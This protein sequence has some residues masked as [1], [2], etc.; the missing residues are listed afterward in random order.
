MGY[1]LLKGLIGLRVKKFQKLSM[2]VTN[3][4]LPEI[5]SLLLHQLR[6]PDFIPSGNV[7]ILHLGVGL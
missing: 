2:R 5:F 4:Y 1:F 7:P 6:N 3:D